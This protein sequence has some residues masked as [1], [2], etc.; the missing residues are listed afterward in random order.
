MTASSTSHRPTPSLHRLA[1]LPLGVALL[2]TAGAA[3]AAPSDIA[4]SAASTAAASG[5]HE[6]GA[7]PT[8]L[9][10]NR[11]GGAFGPGADDPVANTSSV[12][13]RPVVIPAWT[14]ADRSWNRVVDCTRD[15]LD[16]WHVEVTDVDPGDAP[17]VEVVI[18]G[19]PADAG[20]RAGLAG[21]APFSGACRA[22]PSAVAFTFV[23]VVDSSLQVVCEVTVHEFAHTVGLD[24]QLLCQDPM[25]YLRGCGAKSFQDVAAP[26]GEGEARECLC[27][28][29]T[30]NS[31]ELLDERLGLRGEGNPAPVVAIDE[32]AERAVVAPGFTVAAS[33]FDNAGV[34][35]V[36]LWIDGALAATA[37]SEPFVFT[38]PRALV[39]GD[40]T[41][42]LRAIDAGGAVG[43]EVRT[44]VVSRPS[45]VAS[46]AT[47]ADDDAPAGG[48]AAS[49]GASPAMVLAIAGLV[50]ALRRRR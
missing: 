22:L 48:C 47:P 23:E 34:D 27:G 35:E 10:L 4:V 41:L 15:M 17:H 50:A 7:A 30:Q 11:R 38:T 40:H 1:A 26:C 12:I 21:I 2:G 18:G 16:R 36:E 24:H 13:D 45:P 43:S 25:S 32:P 46:P 37:D 3:S 6:S 28:G 9:Y 31:V 39:D 8:L 42:E 44:V 49:G 5:D 19:L 20:V 14:V 33:A 29:D